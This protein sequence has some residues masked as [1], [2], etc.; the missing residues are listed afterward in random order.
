MIFDRYDRI[1]II[2]LPERVDRRREMEAELAKLGLTGRA[3]L[4]FFPAIRPSHGGVFGSVGANGCFQSHHTILQQALEAGQSVLILED[5]CTIFP[6]A[7]TFN[8]RPD[9]EIFWGGWRHATNPADLQRSDII[10]A[11]FMGFSVPVLKKLVPFLQS[12]LN[13][14]TTFDPVIVRSDFDPAIRP[15]VDGAYVW[16]RRYYP[17]FRTEF[18]M[19]ADQR[20]SASDISDRKW[21]DRLP[22]VR[23]LANRARRVKQ[24]LS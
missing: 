4:Q 12:I 15:P 14:R 17:E 11:H 13:P 18:A 7:M 16:F 20:P 1:R 9:T 10:G 5:D 23:T 2:N 3:N 22:G 8:Q 21:F 24:Q 19:L 6:E